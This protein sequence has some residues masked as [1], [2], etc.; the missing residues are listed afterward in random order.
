MMGS[1]ANASRFVTRSVSNLAAYRRD[2]VEGFSFVPHVID[3]FPQM[4]YHAR[5]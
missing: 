3:T 4:N 2:V 1:F 5:D